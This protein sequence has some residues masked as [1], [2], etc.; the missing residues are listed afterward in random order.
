MSTS[1]SVFP[2]YMDTEDN[3]SAYREEMGFMSFKVIVPC[4]FVEL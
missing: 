2:N 1:S 4:I 3:V